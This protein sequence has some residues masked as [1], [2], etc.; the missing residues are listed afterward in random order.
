MVLQRLPVNYQQA[1]P[2]ADMCWQGAEQVSQLQADQVIEFEW[3]GDVARHVGSVVHRYLKMMA[4]QGLSRWDSARLQA[5]QASMQQMLRQ[6]GV[7]DRDLDAA[8]TRVQRVL[9]AVLQDERARWILH[10]QHG[11]ARNEYEVSGVYRDQVINVILDRTFVDADGVR[12]IVD[13]K[14]GSH[15]GAD[16]D[17]FLDNE[18]ERYRGQLER[19][20]A[21]LQHRDE[22]PIKLGLYFPL[23]HGWRE[24]DYKH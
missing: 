2:P 10:P 9:A 15:E 22:R 23:L 17:A 18:Q 14:T 20:A 13:Y 4:E 3:V 7:P 12:W 11:E 19:Y 5:N 16:V 8:A 21:L 1:P 24:W 6:H